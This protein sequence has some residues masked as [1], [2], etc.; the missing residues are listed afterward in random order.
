MGSQLW[1]FNY[2]Y[3]MGITMVTAT[4]TAI[5]TTTTSTTSTTSGRGGGLQLVVIK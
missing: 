3:K 2:G 5:T 1:V 4:T